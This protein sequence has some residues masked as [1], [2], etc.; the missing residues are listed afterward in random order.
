MT[1]DYWCIWRHVY[2]KWR[3]QQKF[4]KINALKHNDEKGYEFACDELDRLWYIREKLL[5][6]HPERQ[7]IDLR[8]RRT[9]KLVW[10]FLRKMQLQGDDV[11]KFD[12]RKVESELRWDGWIEDDAIWDKI[13][14]FLRD[15][16]NE[17]RIFIDP[18]DYYDH[19]S[20]CLED[21]N[22]NVMDVRLLEFYNKFSAKVDIEEEPTPPL[23][24]CK[25]CRPESDCQCEE[26]C[27]LC[28]PRA[29]GYAPISP[30]S[31]L[32]SP[33]RTPGTH[34]L[35]SY[36]KG[37]RLAHPPEKT[38]ESFTDDE[39][40]GILLSFYGAEDKAGRKRVKRRHRNSEIEEICL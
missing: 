16:G 17:G 33:P 22:K 27:L 3:I 37:I 4:A 14:A 31:S 10:R 15:Q 30:V 6:D 29:D 11:A 38:T 13:G 39:A 9:V 1:T 24:E 2:D 36:F 8:N 5:M 18:R 23:I 26:N 12:C 32:P 35:P 40:V 25:E 28:L 7:D 19:Y 20:W 34:P 21:S